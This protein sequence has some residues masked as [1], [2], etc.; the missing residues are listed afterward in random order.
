MIFIW[1]LFTNLTFYLFWLYQHFYYSIYIFENRKNDKKKIKIFFF[2]FCF[3]CYEKPI[4]MEYMKKKLKLKF[5]HW[6]EKKIRSTRIDPSRMNWMCK[7]ISCICIMLICRIFFFMLSHSVSNGENL[8][9]F[10][11]EFYSLI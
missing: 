10:F 6:R 1:N 2:C 7:I 9:F 8:L 4:Y 11:L 5:N 3:C